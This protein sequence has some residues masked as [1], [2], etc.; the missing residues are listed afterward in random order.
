M[1]FKVGNLEL[2]NSMKMSYQLI[3]KYLLFQG[4]NAELNE[5]LANFQDASYKIVLGEAVLFSMLTLKF[6]KKLTS[7]IKI[8]L[9]ERYATL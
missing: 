9:T 4:P 6:L 8:T 1:R 7:Q 5:F 3:V 2:I